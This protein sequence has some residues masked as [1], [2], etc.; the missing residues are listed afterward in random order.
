MSEAD[1]TAEAADAL[2]AVSEA[3]RDVTFRRNPNTVDPVTGALGTGTALITTTVKAVSLPFAKGLASLLRE[4]PEDLRRAK[5]LKLL[6]AAQGFP[7]TPESGDQFD[8]G[9]V[10]G[11]E[12]T[13]WGND[14]LAPAGTS[15]LHSITLYK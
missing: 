10:H 4:L 12:W 7:Y 6:I 14:I 13:V 5:L 15:L 11:D 2:Q 8:V 3:G 1:Y 9:G